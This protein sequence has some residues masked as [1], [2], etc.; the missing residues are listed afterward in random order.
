MFSALQLEIDDENDGRLEVHEILRLELN[1]DLVTLS[2]CDTALG[3]G[4]FAE[5]P[6]GD[7]FVGL[8]RAFLSVGSDSVMATLWQV[9]DRSSVQLMQQFYER[10]EDPDADADTSAALM[11]AQKQLRST[12]GYEHPYYWA[13]FVVVGKINNTSKTTMKALETAL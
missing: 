12:K 1:A 7:E 9:D 8:T 13:P 11:M 4:Y 5:V 3:S 6:A 10:L 2:A